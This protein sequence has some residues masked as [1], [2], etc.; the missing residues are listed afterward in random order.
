VLLD[1]RDLSA[2]VKFND[3]DLIGLPLRL[4]LGKRWLADGRIEAKWRAGAERLRLD[5]AELEADLARL[6][7]S[8][9]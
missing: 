2:G 4:T 9:G 8:R 6:R 7:P 3:A 1:D 5:E